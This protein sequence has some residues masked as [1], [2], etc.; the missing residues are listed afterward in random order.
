MLVKVRRYPMIDFP[1]VFGF[2]RDVDELLGTFLEGD[3]RDSKWTVPMDVVEEED[4]Y[5]LAAELPGVRKED[6]RISVHDGH[7]T[8]SAERKNAEVPENAVWLRNEITFGQFN[9]TLA[10]PGEVKVEEITAG[11]SNGILEVVLPKSEKAR[12]REIKVK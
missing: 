5:I 2:G 3:I 9:R 7:V 1:S 10:L 4:R 8:I 12:V 11:F 6:L